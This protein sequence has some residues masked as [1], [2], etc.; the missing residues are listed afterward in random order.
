MITVSYRTN[1]EMGLT[2]GAPARCQAVR[3]REKERRAE[4]K[5][6]HDP[7]LSRGLE[8]PKCNENNTVREMD[9]RDSVG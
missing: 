2:S 9:C 8:E 5:T 1:D 3:E 4:R 6:N 7:R